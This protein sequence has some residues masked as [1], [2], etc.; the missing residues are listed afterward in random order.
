[1]QSDINTEILRYAIDNGMIDLSGIQEAMKIEEQKRYL[2]L[3]SR[4]IIGL[5]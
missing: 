4:G 5:I 3:D 1:M 2:S